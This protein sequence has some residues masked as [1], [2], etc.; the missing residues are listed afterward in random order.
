[1]KAVSILIASAITLGTVVVLPAQGAEKVYRAK[2]IAVPVKPSA[3]PKTNFKSS[4]QA[5]ETKL[6]CSNQSHPDCP[7]DCSN[8]SHPTCPRMRTLRR[9]QRRSA[10]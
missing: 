4:Q 5:A 1:M 2:A 3:L 8:Q 6:D 7:A 9:T 10:N